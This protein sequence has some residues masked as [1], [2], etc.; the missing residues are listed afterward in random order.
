MCCSSIYTIGANI[1]C[2]VL[3]RYVPLLGPVS[4]LTP[5]PMLVVVQ[6]T[7]SISV[8]EL[9]RDD[10]L[11]FAPLLDNIGPGHISDNRLWLSV[12]TARRGEIG[13]TT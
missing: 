4:I 13:Y 9:T 11:L 7:I 2:D 10:R 5:C 6:G 8:E 12:F 3:T 1:G